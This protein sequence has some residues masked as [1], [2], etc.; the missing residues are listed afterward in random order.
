M[1]RLRFSW[2]TFVGAVCGAV[3]AVVWAV[4]LAVYQPFMQPHG[5]Y[6]D[7]QTGTSTPAIASNNTYWPRDIR[8]LAILLAVAAVVLIAGA[9][10]RAL[11]TAAGSAVAWLAAD[12]WLDRL[13]VAGRGTATW[14]AVAAVVWFAVTVA[15]AARLAAREEHSEPVAYLVSGTAAVLAA[16]TTVV[17]T[18]W[19]EPV[20]QPDQIRIEDA[21]TVLKGALAVTFA[22]VAVALVAHRLTARR[23]GFLAMFGTLA[24]VAAWAA[25]STY[26]PVGGLGLFGMPVAASLAIAATRRASVWRLI[27]TA[28]TCVA[29]LAALVPFYFACATI[30]A[31]MTALAR[32]PPVNSADTDLPLSLLGLALGITL[33]VVGYVTTAPARTPAPPDMRVG[34]L[35]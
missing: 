7:P 16:V 17:T 4:G 34:A 18:P 31:A 23:A 24:A 3:A 35:E 13:D 26:G 5:F 28:I 1:G 15:L 22:A 6:A 27:G 14:L 8:Q 32:N 33:A 29:A 25:T 19:D 30:G 10:P 2:T 20:T 21:S 9:R 12:L 11:L